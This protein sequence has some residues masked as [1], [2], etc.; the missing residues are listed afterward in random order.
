MYRIHLHLQD[1]GERREEEC[2]EHIATGHTALLYQLYGYGHT[3]PGRLQLQLEQGIFSDVVDS[4]GKDK[5]KVQV[6]K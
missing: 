6:K 1:K 4:Q 5:V 3:V 2:G